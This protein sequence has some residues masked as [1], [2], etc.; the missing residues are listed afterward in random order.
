MSHAEPPTAPNTYT[1][2]LLNAL[3]VAGRDLVR[4]TLGVVFLL[5]LV[6]TCLWILRPVMPAILWSSAIVISTWPLMLGLERR[7]GGRR[8][9]AAALMTLLLTLV[10]LVPLLLGVLTIVDNAAGIGE[11]L[12]SLSTARMPEPPGWL[13]R[14]PIAGERL[15]ATW[16]QVVEDGAQG[17]LGRLAPYG[18]RVLTWLLTRLGGAG[19]VLLQFAL[20]VVGVVFLYRSGDAVGGRVRRFA[21]ALAGEHGESAVVLA[22]QATRSVALGVLLTAVVQALLAA[23]G[24]LVA[25]VP[26]V[27]I[28]TVLMVVTGMAQLGPMPVLLPA[29][30]W[31]YFTGDVFWGTALL[32][33]SGF[34]GVIDNVLRP[35]FIRRGADLSMML[36]F[37]GVIGGLVAFGV[38][39][40]FIG[41]VVLAVTYRLLE[42]WIAREESEPSRT[43]AALRAD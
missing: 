23:L 14:L 12:E 33:W 10:L 11:W 16:R 3:P 42:A 6:G 26:A 43:P 37:V 8:T 18:N 36:V 15:A 30:A 27:G 31:L 9:L 17:L 38:V 32:V 1:V 13:E 4:V 35:M 34:V 25:G 20:T 22:A 19:M 29:V 41:P 40:L 7:L 28:L 24:L 2:R 21:R 5:A 39:G